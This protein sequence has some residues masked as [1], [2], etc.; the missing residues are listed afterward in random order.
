MATERIQANVEMIDHKEIK[1]V[2]IA[3]WEDAVQLMQALTNSGYM[4]KMWKG[5]VVYIIEFDWKDSDWSGRELVWVDS[6]WFVV[7]DTE[8]VE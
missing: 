8:P 2:E 6:D 3:K 5:E 4:V 1:R 7:D